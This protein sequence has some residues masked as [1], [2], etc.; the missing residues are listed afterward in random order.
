MF[1]QKTSSSSSGFSNMF[2]GKLSKLTTGKLKDAMQAAGEQLSAK[3]ASAV[4][5]ANQA[6]AEAVSA[7]LKLILKMPL[8]LYVYLI[9]DKLSDFSYIYFLS[10][11]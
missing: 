10:N 7:F 3:A 4:E 2:G 1:G 11:C 9:A 5:K 8:C 6:M